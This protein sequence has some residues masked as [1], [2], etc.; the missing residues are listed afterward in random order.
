MW[1]I[2]LKSNFKRQFTSLHFN[3]AHEW[4][5]LIYFNT[6][7]KSLK[8]Y[9]GLQF[10]PYL[11]YTTDTPRVSNKRV[12]T[13]VKYIFFPKSPFRSRLNGMI[14]ICTATFSPPCWL[15]I[16]RYHLPRSITRN[17]NILRHFLVLWVVFPLCRYKPH[18]ALFERRHSFGLK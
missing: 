15:F 7:Q 17:D 8:T 12:P 1:S 9:A 6:Q 4:R 5:I 10:Q 14:H 13:L 18:D 2:S 3:R 16:E 11:L